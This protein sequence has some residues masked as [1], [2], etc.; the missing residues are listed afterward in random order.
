MVETSGGA[1]DRVWLS[2]RPGQ[3]LRYLV[4]QRGRAVPADQ[5]V[6]AL[7]PGGDVGAGENVRY[8]VHLL[9]RR[10]EPQR[11]PRGESHSVEC[12]GGAYALAQG[13]WIDAQAFEELV[14]GA[15]TAADDDEHDVALSRLDRALDLYRG[16]F[17]SDE[18]YADWAMAERER[19]RGM[20]ED[21]LRAAAGV[22]QQRHDFGRALE[23][24]RSLAEMGCY[25][26]DVQLQVISLCLRCGRRSEAARR[27]DAFRA[28]LRREF[29]VEPEFDLAVASGVS[30]SPALAPPLRPLAA[31]RAR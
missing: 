21:A 9:R 14:D 30:L 26:S 2:Q 11:P 28:R 12:L 5:I 16:D 19:M 25:D 3:L 15:S 10:L 8:L 29:G 13:V 1:V 31:S 24:A 23:Y 20:A 17:L 6:Q 22:C 18:P 27:Y 7:W 4:C